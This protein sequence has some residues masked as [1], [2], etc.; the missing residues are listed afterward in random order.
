MVALPYFAVDDEGMRLVRSQKGL[1]A[2]IGRALG[3]TRQAVWAWK[4]VPADYLPAIERATGIPRHRL[5]PDI[6]LP[7]HDSDTARAGKD[8]LAASQAI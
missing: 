5:R 6:C 3:M 1:M 8:T 4:K 7:P 2:Q